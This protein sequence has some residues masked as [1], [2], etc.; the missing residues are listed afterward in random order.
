MLSKRNGPAK[1][2]VKKMKRSLRK[3]AITH[4]HRYLLR[5]N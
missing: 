5:E 3:Y 4:A 2:R 1:K